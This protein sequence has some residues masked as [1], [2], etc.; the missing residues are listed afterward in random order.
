MKSDKAYVF[1]VLDGSVEDKSLT[2]VSSDPAD[3]VG[4]LRRNAK[5]A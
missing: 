1:K 3:L 5:T 4:W 2:Y